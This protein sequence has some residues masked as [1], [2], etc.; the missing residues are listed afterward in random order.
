M[1][2]FIH[3]KQ[4]SILFGPG[5]TLYLHRERKT[6][7]K[8]YIVSG[9]PW[10]SYFNTGKLLDSLYTLLI[11]LS[12]AQ[13]RLSLSLSL[14]IHYSTIKHWSGRNIKRAR[15]C[16][17]SLCKWGQEL[18]NFFLPARF[19]AQVQYEGSLFHAALNERSSQRATDCY[20]PPRPN[21]VVSAQA[22]CQER[23]RGTRTKQPGASTKQ[24]WG[25]CHRMGFLLCGKP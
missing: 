12:L 11:F 2:D 4:A 5:C 21:G 13:I 15:V 10:D 17:H 23:K 22:G 7:E 1:L 6:R 8:N 16:Q 3:L 9:N 18:I 20:F 19:Q 24:E 14:S 25:I